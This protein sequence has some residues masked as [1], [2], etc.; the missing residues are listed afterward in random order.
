MP[1]RRLPR[2]R[3]GGCLR[4]SACLDVF[5]QSA[6]RGLRTAD[7]PRRGVR[8]TRFRQPSGMAG[9]QLDGGGQVRPAERQP[10][11]GAT[12]RSNGDPF[13]S[14]RRR[15]DQDDGRE[16]DSGIRVVRRHLGRTSTARLGCPGPTARGT[17][18]CGVALGLVPGD[19]RR[20]RPRRRRIPRR[21]CLR[22]A[23]P[24]RIGCTPGAPRATIQHRLGAD[25]RPI[26]LGTVVE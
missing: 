7:G 8:R 12:A 10:I 2:R 21:R 17:G 16:I 3:L 19:H 5:T 9:V 20:D 15:P 6:R 23:G 26:R 22:P 1:R 24:S 11:S 14:R 18:L 25:P 13:Q 4:R